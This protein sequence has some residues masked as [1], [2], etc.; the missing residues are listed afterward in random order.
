MMNMHE[1]S[2]GKDRCKRK[3]ICDGM[4]V[5]AAG[6]EGPNQLKCVCVCVRVCLYVLGVGESISTINLFAN[7]TFIQE[8]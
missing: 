5:K 6:K 4:S 1:V 8:S 3:M 2:K 7:C